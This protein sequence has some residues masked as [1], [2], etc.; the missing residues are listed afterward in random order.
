MRLPRGRKHGFLVR[1]VNP[2]PFR[3]AS[4]VGR[5]TGEGFQRSRGA[6]GRQP[7][8]LY[9]SLDAYPVRRHAAY[10]ALFN[11]HTDPAE[12]QA[13]RSATEA[14]TILGNDRFK[15]NIEITLKRRT[16][17]LPHD[18]DRKSEVFQDQREII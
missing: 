16:E 5:A 14:G 11:A 7:H 12:L 4:C 9:E 13:I 10:R 6:D 1:T 15:E 18:G 8:Y 2:R 17:L 3:I